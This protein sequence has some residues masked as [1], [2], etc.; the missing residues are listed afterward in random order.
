M[1]DLP[2][3]TIKKSTKK[4]LKSERLTTFC[5]RITGGWRGGRG[6]RPEHTLKGTKACMALSIHR[7]DTHTTWLEPPYGYRVEC[8]GAVFYFIG[9]EEAI[10]TRLVKE[11]SKT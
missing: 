11:L 10:M 9:S 1:S 4:W 3:R 6:R 7:Q 8:R 2:A 5:L